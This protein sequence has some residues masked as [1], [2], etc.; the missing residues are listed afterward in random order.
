[1]IAVAA[2]LIA[3]LPAFVI[4][5]GAAV[6]TALRLRA[7][8]IVQLFGRTIHAS[9]QLPEVGLATGRM[10]SDS[11]ADLVGAAVFSVLIFPLVAL[12]LRRRTQSAVLT[13]K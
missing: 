6:G 2:P 1:M 13:T 8:R 11:A 12:A 5:V 4:L 3:E 7:P 9:S 10:R